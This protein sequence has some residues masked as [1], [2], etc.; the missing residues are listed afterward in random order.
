[1]SNAIP[2]PAGIVMGRIAENLTIINVEKFPRKI[3]AMICCSCSPERSW[4]T[5]GDREPAHRGE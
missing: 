1:M 5:G 3:K 2:P 4:T